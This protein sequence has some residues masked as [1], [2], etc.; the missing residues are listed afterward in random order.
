[1]R[2]CVRA[3]LRVCVCACVR[4]CVCVHAFVRVVVLVCGACACV[5]VYKFPLANR[6]APVTG[7]G[8][9]RSFPN[10]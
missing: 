8:S 3:Y 7:L 1:M 6:T 10:S 2:A 9:V 4:I 5:G